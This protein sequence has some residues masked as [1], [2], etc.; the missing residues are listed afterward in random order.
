[1]A[2]FDRAKRAERRNGVCP[3]SRDER[4]G[5]PTTRRGTQKRW[6]RKRKTSPFFSYFIWGTMARSVIW[7]GCEGGCRQPRMVRGA[8]S[9]CIVLA[10]PCRTARTLQRPRVSSSLSHLEVPDRRRRVVDRATLDRLAVWLF[11]TCTALPTPS[12]PA[13]AVSV[14][15]HVRGHCGER[16]S[17]SPPN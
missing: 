4:V 5:T 7:N 11:A 10:A 13:V 1:M 9:A 17:L 8:E 6:M 15:V 2:C 14:D 12:A 16:R 3:E